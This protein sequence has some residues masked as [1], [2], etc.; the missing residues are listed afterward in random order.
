MNIRQNIAAPTSGPNLHDVRKVSIIRLLL[1]A[2][3]VAIVALGV[4]A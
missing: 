4:K 2:L 3:S 1:I